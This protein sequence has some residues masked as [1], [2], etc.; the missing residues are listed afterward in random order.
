MRRKNHDL[1]FVDAPIVKFY[2]ETASD[3]AFV[4][5]LTAVSTDALG[6]YPM[7]PILLDMWVVAAFYW[8]AKQFVD[9][10][11]DFGARGVVIFVSDGLGSLAPWRWC[12]CRD[13]PR[14]H[15]RTQQ[16]RQ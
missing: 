15:R 13:R 2:T 10:V 5:V 7:A 14:R 16:L 3:V 12:H 1:D 4:V 6:E 9:S 11:R 8:E